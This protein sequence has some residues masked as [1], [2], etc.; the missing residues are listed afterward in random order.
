MQTARLTA[1]TRQGGRPTPVARLWDFVRGDVQRSAGLLLLE[2]T[3]REAWAQRI[4]KAV[5]TQRGAYS[6][7]PRWYG[8]DL[9]GAR[10]ERTPGL[11]QAMLE[12]EVRACV[13]RDVGTSRTG[14]YVFV[15]G[16]P[17]LLDVSFWV[18]SVPELGGER[19]E[20]ERVFRVLGSG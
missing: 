3:P 15:Q 19:L 8:V 4:V 16:E 18:E 7:Y 5:L 9:E 6:G 10:R 2:A 13:L 11:R 12:R 1:T 20:I 17:D 14:G